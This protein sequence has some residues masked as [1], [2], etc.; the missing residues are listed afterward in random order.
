[1]TDD[2]RPAEIRLAEAGDEPAVKTVIDAAFQPYIERIGVVPVPMEADHAANIAAG[3]VYV[4]GDPV[5][6][7]LVLEEHDDHLYLD[8]IAVHPDAHGQGIGRRLLAFVDARARALALPEIR[9]YTNAMM[10]ENQKIYPKCGYELMERRAEGP[11]DR[12]HYRKRL[13]P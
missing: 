9:L 12:L 8:V 13:S 3:R 10:W 11:Y 4:T 6:G 1:M 2:I 7:L 5:V